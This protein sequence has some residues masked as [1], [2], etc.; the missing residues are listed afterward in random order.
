MKY[1]YDIILNFNERLYEFYE[2]KDNDN[3]EYI[4]KIPIFKVSNN[5]LMDLKN[6]KVVMDI[7]F[8]KNMYN[9]CEIYTNTGISTIEYAS[10]FCSDDSIIAIEFNEKG[11]SIF[12]SDLLI[13]EALD[14]LDYVKKLKISNIEYNIVSKN[15]KLLMTRKEVGM[16]KFIKKELNIIYKND[17]IDK[18]KYI[19]YECFNKIEDNINKIILDLEKYISNSP[20]KLFDL[21]MLSCSKGLQ[22]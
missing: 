19:Y 14:I 5:V 21:L 4:K 22:K 1:I 9:K 12:R 6:N 20:N 3:I 10:L 17:N 13:D 18:L 8:I 2:W 16:L 15:K 7:E 11:V